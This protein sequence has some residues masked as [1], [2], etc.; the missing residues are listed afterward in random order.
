M[1]SLTGV[2]SKPFLSIPREVASA[3]DP[4]SVLNRTRVVKPR[5]EKKMHKRVID[6]GVKDGPGLSVRG[7]AG[8]RWPEPGRARIG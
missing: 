8:Q 3:L 4:R 7:A 2:F 6:L 5:V 1:P